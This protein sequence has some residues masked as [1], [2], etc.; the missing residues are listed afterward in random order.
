MAQT[1]EQRKIKRLE[2]EVQRLKAE[3]DDLK[4]VSAWRQSQL[5]NERE[6]RRNFQR[7]LKDV[8]QEDDVKDLEIW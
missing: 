3:I 7:L 2:S 8:V 6:W 5:Y 4:K 1:A